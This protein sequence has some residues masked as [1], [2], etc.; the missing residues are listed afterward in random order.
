MLKLI[1]GRAGSGKT[2]QIMEEINRAVLEDRRGLVLLVP[3]QY[4]HEAER[5]LCRVCGDR[6][7]L[8]AEVLSFSRLCSL[9]FDE[10]GT[11]GIKY[12]DKG[13]RLLSMS[14]AVS[15]VSSRLTAYSSAPRSP[16]LQSMLLAA[17]TELKTACISSEMLEDA[18][19]SADKT[20]AE[21]L[22]DLAL[23]NE[24]YNAVIS[25]GSAD[26]ADKLTRLAELI[27]SSGVGAGGV[28]IDGFTD[29]TAQ[30]LGIIETLLKR[31]VNITV[32]L[33]CD[34]LQGE[35][36]ELFD[37][38]RKAACRL[39]HM[40]TEAG[41]ECVKDTLE[42]DSSE[43]VPALVFLEQHMFAYTS[44]QC[45]DENGAIRLYSAQ[46]LSAECELAASHALYLAREK[47]CRW[48]DIA[49]AV[50]GFDEC[51]GM[52][53]GVFAHYGVPLYSSGKSDVMKKPI[54][55]L[56]DAAFE[57]LSGGWESGDILSYLKTGLT[58]LSREDCDI[59]ENYLFTWGIRGAGAWTR[60]HPWQ[61]GLKGFS[62]A[63]DENAAEKLRRINELRKI[64]SAP[65]ARLM[66]SGKK[67]ETAAQQALAV[68]GFL[69]DLNLAE[70]L[71]DKAGALD[72]RGEQAAAMEYRQLW[73]ILVTA[74]EQCAAILRDMPMA[75]AE[76]GKL[77][78]LV[79]SQ[80]DVGT[81]PVSLDLVSAGDMDR[82]RRRHIKHLIVLGASEDRLP[83]TGEGAGV[84]SD[85]ERELLSGLGIELGD[86]KAD[87]FYR[88]L[89]LIYNCL[90]LPSETL[91][92]SFTSGGGEG[93]ESRPSLVMHRLCALTGAGIEN[94][95]VSGARVSAVSP[96][97]ELAACAINGAASDEGIATLEWLY[98]KPEF[99]E[100]ISG[101]S[102]AAEQSR[103]ALSR[104]SVS[105][106]Y[107][108]KLRLSASRVDTFSSCRFKYFL[109]YG[110]RARPRKRAKFDPPE[111]GTFMHY[112][113]EGFTREV[114]ENG[115]FKG[116]DQ[117]L[118][119][120]LAEKYVNKYISEVLNN[121]SEKS[122]RFVYLFKRLM[123]TVKQV[124]ADMAEELSRSDFVP[125][126]FELDFSGMGDLPP[127]IIGEGDGEMILTGI[128]DRVDGWVH[129][130]KLY[131]R[132]VDYKTGKKSFDFTDVWNGMGLQMLMYLFALTEFGEKRYG[133]EIV[134]AGVLYTPARD[135]LVK[136]KRNLNDED[137]VAERARSLTRSGLILDDDLV[138]NAMEQ[139]QEPRYLPLKFKNG[140]PSGDCLAS[141]EHFGE[142][143]RHIEDT[144]ASLAEELRN[145]SINANPYFRSSAENTCLY[146]DF[147]DACHFDDK[148]DR[149]KYVSGLKA[150]EFWKKLSEGGGK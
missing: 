72:E 19:Q 35:G 86:G 111:M 121:F 48:R 99:R 9:V 25:Q 8:C 52:L 140:V 21:K 16:E 63:A 100:R 66:E 103:G 101:I 123:G 134:P 122:P 118:R 149:K 56:I 107:G 64:V 53:E 14:L 84:F 59:L 40:A 143:N 108:D 70:R 76:F 137:V 26:P 47:G 5:E 61:S 129:D 34:T 62:G 49:V 46:S 28:Y 115:G 27:P 77:L 126:E 110:L 114:M 130:E 13:G 54:P 31:G 1:L 2:A 106:L 42:H 136:A 83:K 128:A 71:S 57:I 38:S 144:L 37:A 113:L 29:F 131:L 89:C 88:E 124:A 44:K 90:T 142:L 135:V 132:V 33:T 82:M 12:L 75:Q 80:Y 36:T 145:G 147:F 119:D 85:G 20:L 15:A 58:G 65:L 141:L 18:A 146:C 93:G 41:H 55:A 67:A 109:Q 22:R 10:L 150:P 138:I 81:I 74:L 23:V 102:R 69:E 32:C 73:E 117:E 91:T 92:V 50:R 68:S 3:E 116:L 95:S 30:E 120:A 24:A 45:A 105:M 104:R 7:C 96:A 78:C 60:A 125:L 43:D 6:L 94:F 97:L 4:S 112:V 87:S 148:R 39:I 127:V 98:S 139:G 133:R 79:L 11:G 17:V 51:R